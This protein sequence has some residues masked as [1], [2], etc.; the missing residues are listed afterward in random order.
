MK[1][2]G[3]AHPTRLALPL[4]NMGACFSLEP[5]KLGSLTFQHTRNAPRCPRRRNLFHT[6]TCDLKKVATLILPKMKASPT[7]SESDVLRTIGG[8]PTT[9]KASDMRSRAQSPGTFR[10][11]IQ[12]TIGIDSDRGMSI[13]LGALHKQINNLVNIHPLTVIVRVDPKT[14]GLMNCLMI[15]HCQHSWCHGHFSKP[16]QS[17]RTLHRR[18]SSRVR[19]VIRIRNETHAT[20]ANGFQKNSR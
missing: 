11:S 8:T 17:P 14:P 7:R 10:Q 5:S 6:W 12:Q 4:N 19:G 20:L 16:Q 13:R 18:P 9:T 1:M 3:G 15:R 2:V